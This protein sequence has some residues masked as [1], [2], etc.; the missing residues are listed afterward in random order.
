MIYV[1]MNWEARHPDLP[2]GSHIWVAAWIF[3]ASIAVAYASLKAYDMPV[4][5]WLKEHWL[6][7]R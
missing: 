1:H 6:K 3:I 4:R 2:L 5:E 7:R